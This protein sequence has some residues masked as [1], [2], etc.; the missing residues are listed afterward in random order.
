MG[1][2]KKK[3]K[4]LQLEDFGSVEFYCARCD[5]TFEIDWETIWA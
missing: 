2:R 1:K 4:Q 5:Y 3:T